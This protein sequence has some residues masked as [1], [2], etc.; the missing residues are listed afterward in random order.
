[1]AAS[2]LPHLPRPGAG[3]GDPLPPTP[4]SAQLTAVGVPIETYFMHQLFNGVEVKRFMLC[5]PAGRELLSGRRSSRGGKGSAAVLKREERPGWAVRDVQTQREGCG[6]TAAPAEKCPSCGTGPRPGCCISWG[7]PCLLLRAAPGTRSQACREGLGCP[8]LPA[9]RPHARGVLTTPAAELNTFDSIYYE[10]IM[11]LGHVLAIFYAWAK[12]QI[13][14]F[15]K[16][17]FS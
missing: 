12:Q 4:G 11:Q 2:V 9:P 7:L 14:L 17:C 1:M 16:N 3:S 10:K 5:I 13:P 8:G 15:K 6:A